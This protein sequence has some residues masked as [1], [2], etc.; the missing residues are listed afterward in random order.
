MERF[1]RG[2][3]KALC[4]VGVFI[5]LFVLIA[6]VR[7]FSGTGSASPETLFRGLRTVGVIFLAAIICF[8]AS[9][10]RQSPR[11]KTSQP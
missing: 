2:L 8:C 9:K 10:I 11:K 6:V 7:F 3:A 1:L 5:S 4:A